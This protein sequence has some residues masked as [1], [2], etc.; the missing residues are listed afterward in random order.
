MVFSKASRRLFVLSSCLS[1][2]ALFGG[3]SAVAQSYDTEVSAASFRAKGDFV[4]SRN[5][6]SF[7]ATDST[8]VRRVVRNS[9]Q[10]D[11]ESV[12]IPDAIAAK[13][14]V[15]VS[16][17]GSVYAVSEGEL[18]CSLTVFTQ[19]STVL[20]D[21]TLSTEA[22]CKITGASANV[23]DRVILAIQTASTTKLVLFLNGSSETLWDAERSGLVSPRLESFTINDLNTAPFTVSHVVRGRRQF[24]S[25]FWVPAGGVSALTFPRN[26]GPR[27]I[28][29]DANN[30]NKYL[31]TVPS[32]VAVFDPSK[33]RIVVSKVSANR[34]TSNG[35]PF[36]ASTIFSP[37]ITRTVAGCFA[38]GGLSGFKVQFAAINDERELLLL[39][40]SPSSS[41]VA[42]VI[43]FT[44]NGYPRCTTTRARRPNPRLH[45]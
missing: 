26:A 27:P 39:G 15:A 5:G 24:A 32:G 7:V 40:T 4:F 16:Y 20:P 28:V 19:H 8:G 31:I 42:K 2:V 21:V 12:V 29:R 10:F 3:S 34:L 9:F 38:V 33:R 17:Y 22:G 14:I 25:F 45:R 6:N 41:K 1:L 43:P 36:N 18:G 37:G 35:T 30:K 44:E 13:R 23:A 11:E